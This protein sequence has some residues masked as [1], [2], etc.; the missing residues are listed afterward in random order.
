MI[1]LVEK[2]STQENLNDRKIIITENPEHLCHLQFLLHTRLFFFKNSGG[3]FYI[4]FN[5]QEVHSNT[6]Y[7]VPPLHFQHLSKN[8][9]QDF[10]CIDIDN[11]LLKSY[12]KQLLYFIKYNRQK[13]LTLPPDSTP[14]YNYENLLQLK[15]DY[16]EQRIIDTI[17]AWIES[18][19]PN[20]IVQR[21]K[22][23]NYNYIKDADNFLSL[24]SQKDL[25]IESC[26]VNLLALEMFSTERN[27]H[28]ICNSAFGI[29]A[30]DVIKYHLTTKAIY[31]L[32][33]SQNSITDISNELNFSSLNVFT[34]Y[35][36]RITGYT[37]SEIRT[38]SKSNVK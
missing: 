38:V 11:S 27:I 19:I 14:N 15:S 26:K 31:L 7:I 30:K 22:H 17:V 10:L 12:H 18:S 33:E 20:E 29:C 32:S 24:L 8:T 21:I 35:M 28:R 6:I 3:Y 34:R 1:Q 16:D 2:Y 13:S 36:R 23:K 37:P 25:T 4:D 5:K 9:F